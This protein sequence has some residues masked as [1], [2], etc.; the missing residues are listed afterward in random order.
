MRPGDGQGNPPAYVRRQPY[1]AAMER[2]VIHET[3]IHFVDVFR[4]LLGEMG[5]VYAELQRLNPSIA[6]ED[7]GTVVFGFSADAQLHA[8]LDC[9][10]P[11]KQL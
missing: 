2:F 10:R 5:S 1:F 4:S 3:G 11:V 7:S 8:V 6:G 9:N